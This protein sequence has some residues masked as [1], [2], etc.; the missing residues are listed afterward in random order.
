MCLVGFDQKCSKLPF[1]G[2]KS[3]DVDGVDVVLSANRDV[4]QLWYTKVS[5]TPP[6]AT[7]PNAY[8]DSLPNIEKILGKL[9]KRSKI[10]PY[11]KFK[12]KSW[13]FGNEVKGDKDDCLRLV[14][15]VIGSPARGPSL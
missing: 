5:S 10:L 6:N 12:E 1:M 15:L 14:D 7:L 4:V 9:V 13:I 11:K 2:S 8:F 3:W